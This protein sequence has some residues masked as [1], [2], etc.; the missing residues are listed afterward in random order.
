MNTTSSNSW[1]P[2]R[3]KLERAKTEIREAVNSL[4]AP[5]LRE[6]I[7]TNNAVSKEDLVT[8]LALQAIN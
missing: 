6:Q 5:L 3:T 2:V 1:G 8:R 7:R 4:S